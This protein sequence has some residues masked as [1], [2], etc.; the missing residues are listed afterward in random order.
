MLLA[1]GPVDLVLVDWSMPEM[2]GLEF[3]TAVR[4]APVSMA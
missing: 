2:D 1:E 4:A 3:L